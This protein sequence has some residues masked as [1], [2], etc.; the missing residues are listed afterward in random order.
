MVSDTALDTNVVNNN[1]DNSSRVTMG[2]VNITVQN[3][4]HNWEDA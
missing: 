1:I 2:D 3:V 4:Y